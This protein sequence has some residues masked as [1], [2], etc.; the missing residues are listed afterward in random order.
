MPGSVEV[1]TFGGFVDDIYDC[2]LHPDNWERVLERICLELD[3]MHGVLGL[4]APS[5]GEPL[6]RIQHGMQQEWFERMPAYAFETT[7]FWGG[8]EKVVSYPEGEVIIHS[9]ANPSYNY[10]SNRFAA[11]W[12]QPQGI[13]DMA[14]VTVSK[15]AK[16]LGTLV[17]SSRRLLEQHRENE[18]ELLRLLSPHIRRAISIGHLLDFQKFEQQNLSLALDT[19]PNGFVLLSADGTISHCNSAA[20]RILR[21]NDALKV[22][23]GRL[24]MRDPQLAKALAAAIRLDNKKILS[25]RGSGLPAKGSNGEK[26]MLYVLPLVSKNLKNRFKSAPMTAV[27]LTSE[28]SQNALPHDALNV[29]YDLTPAEIRVCELLVAGDT[30][31]EIAEKV[32]V[33]VSTI[34]THLLRIF[35]KTGVNRQAELVRKISSLLIMSP[36]AAT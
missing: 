15:D 30:P 1:S 11:E 21:V 27:F 8:A 34:R 28:G 18:M 26:G 12:C 19:I 29:L 2:V 31:S 22:V 6:L 17:F 13:R 14:G 7:T 4:Y 3:L 25:E 10:A 35:E 20:E 5:S 9:I 23:D 36:K 32:G 24:T 16:G 33:A